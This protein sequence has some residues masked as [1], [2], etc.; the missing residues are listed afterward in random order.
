MP[1]ESKNMRLCGTLFGFSFLILILLQSV[2][3]RETRL[4]LGARLRGE[5]N[6]VKC[7]RTEDCRNHLRGGGQGLSWGHGLAENCGVDSGG[8][9]G[10]GVFGKGLAAPPEI[11]L[12][13]PDALRLRDLRRVRGAEFGGVSCAQGPARAGDCED[14]MKAARP[15]CAP[16]QPKLTRYQIGTKS[17]ARRGILR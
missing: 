4:R 9:H 11:Q 6:N 12:R 10:R 8:S 16:C 2:R 5:P 3:R 7:T 15:E 17:L 14:E 1:E 13:A